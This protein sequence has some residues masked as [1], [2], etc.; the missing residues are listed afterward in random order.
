[1]L[2]VL[3]SAC[4]GPRSDQGKV[5]QV[6]NQGL[7][8]APVCYPVPVGVPLESSTDKSLADS[9]LALKE[10]LAQG[11]AKPGQISYQGF[12]R[13]GVADG[14]VFAE[15]A[16]ALIQTPAVADAIRQ[17]QPCLQFGHWKIKTIE[18][19]DSGSDASGKPVATVRASIEFVPR[20]WIKLTRTNPAWAS[21][22][23]NIEQ[24]ERSQWLYRLLKSGE[25]YFF[26]GPG[27]KLK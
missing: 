20:D 4:S 23:G 27:E 25:E 5:A 26:T 9:S 24:L 3:L 11:L 14:Y 13:P 21:Y 1:M 16:A 18:A 7:S 17:K 6:I 2:L 15:S 22:W 19:L 12:S 10:L 8:A